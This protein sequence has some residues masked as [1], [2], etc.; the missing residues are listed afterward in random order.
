[1]CPS[2]EF[3]NSAKDI[4]APRMNLCPA[5]SDDDKPVTTGRT[6]VQAAKRRHPTGSKRAAPQRGGIRPTRDPRLDRGE[7]SGQAGLRPWASPAVSAQAGQRGFKREARPKIL[8]PSRRDDLLGRYGVSPFEG[9]TEN[10][11]RRLQAGES[12]PQT[13]FDNFASPT[14]VATETA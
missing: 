13:S 9:V 5:A 2:V 14:Y 4:H 6:G 8:A 3:F 12:F 7:R 1:M 11:E 10:A